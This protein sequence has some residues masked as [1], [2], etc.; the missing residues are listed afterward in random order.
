[1]QLELEAAQEKIEE[2][3]L[4][5]EI[6]KAEMSERA[7]GGSGE[8]A[9]SKYEMKQLEQQNSRLRDTLVRLEMI[10]YTGNQ[11]QKTLCC[12]E[13]IPV[14]NVCDQI[15]TVCSKSYLVCSLD[16]HLEVFVHFFQ[17]Q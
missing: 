4:D 10:Y 5:L 7:G 13:D 8:S 12:T 3:T 15:C 14:C 6:I 17:S 1:M 9:V 11:S 16:K 2:L